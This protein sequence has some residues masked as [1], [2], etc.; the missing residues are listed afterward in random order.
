MI[1]ENNVKKKSGCEPNLKNVFKH[2]IDM[3]VFVEVFCLYAVEV[4]ISKFRTFLHV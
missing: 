2:K 1:S 4:Q 3:S